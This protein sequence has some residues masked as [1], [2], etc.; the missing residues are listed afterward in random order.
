MVEPVLHSDHKFTINS[1]IVINEWAGRLGNNLIQLS[2]AIYICLKYQCRL[3]YPEHPFLHQVTLQFNREDARIDYINRFYDPTDCRGVYPNL[4]ERRFI[5]L[6]YIREM[7]NFNLDEPTLGNQQ[8]PLILQIR[9]GDTFENPVPH[10][11]VPS[12]LA[13]F[14]TII[15]EHSGRSVLIVCENLKNPIIRELASR[16]DRCSVQSLDLKIDIRTIVNAENLVITIGTFGFVL[17]LLSKKIKHLYV[18]DIGK[19]LLDF[20]FFAAKDLQ[21]DF[22]VHR[23]RLIDYI[24]FGEWNNSPD[25]VRKLYEHPE[26]KVISEFR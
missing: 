8:N 20:G 13:F 18:D 5:M 23:F 2:N 25:Q 24:P 6:N 7:I 3:D 22:E 14:S 21:L 4:A 1:T 12:P 17:A 15:K 9:S 10:K 11:Y 16:Y 26:S 19:E